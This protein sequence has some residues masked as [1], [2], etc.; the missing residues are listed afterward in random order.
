MNTLKE[1][2]S[3]FIKDLPTGEFRHQMEMCIK[4]SEQYDEQSIKQLFVEFKRRL[5]TGE[6]SSV[7]RKQDQW[8]ADELVKSFII[9]GFRIGKTISFEEGSFTYYDKETLGNR[10]CFDKIRI[11]SSS[12]VIRDG[13]YVAPGVICMSPS[14]INIGAYVNKN[15][16]LDSNS[17]IGSCAYIGENVHIGAGTQIGG[18]LEPANSIPV[19]VEDNVFIGG[20]CGL[21]DGLLICQGAAIGSGTVINGSTPVYDLINN[22]IYSKKN[23]NFYIPSGAVVVP[24]ARKIRNNSM[25]ADIS[26]QTPLIVKY[27]EHSGGRFEIEDVLREL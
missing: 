25:D 16:L 14:F 23:N 6:L 22:C 15:V 4:N 5:N 26:I 3:D 11:T 2:E 8:Y 9:M 7:C 1:E 19:I 20:N 12:A 13:A 24:G 27:L 10:H 21:Y 18:V 17:L